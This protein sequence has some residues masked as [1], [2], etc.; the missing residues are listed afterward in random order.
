MTTYPGARR[1]DRS[2]TVDSSGLALAAYQW[3]QDSDPPLLLAHGGFDFAGTLDGFAPRLAAGGW[4][5][6]SWD[7]RGHG[8]SEHAAMYNWEA[9]TRDAVAVLKS[10]TS[11]PVPV[12]GHSKGGGLMMALADVRP[13]L[14]T[15]L[16]NLDGLP[17]KRTMP[18]VADRDRTRLM[19]ADLAQRLDYRRVAHESIRKP[20]TPDE[21]AKRR[22]RMNPRLDADWLRYLVSVGAKEEADGWRWKLDPT[23]RF[24]GFGPYRPEWSLFRL[25]GLSI[26]FM[27]V[28][29]G[30][31]EEM[32]WGTEKADVEPWIPPGGQVH[33]MEDLGH[34]VHIEK[35]DEI[36][37]LTLEFLS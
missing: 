5:V 30:V 33:V 3:G 15:A 26:P 14:V 12:V 20:G 24:G 19:S 11:A 18:D 34:F 28:L 27:A 1:P 36:A 21:L 22:A 35:P 16:V 13:D 7:Q 9:D 25:V 32:G 10:T 17:S 6:I 4:R 2:W 31:Q 23:M 37:G 8:D 29:G